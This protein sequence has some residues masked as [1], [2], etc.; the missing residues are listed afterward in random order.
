MLILVSCFMEVKKKT[1]KKIVE[2]IL[3]TKVL[4]ETRMWIKSSTTFTIVK[5]FGH[6]GNNM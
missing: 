2:L 5:A 6:D 1:N 3:A 4:L